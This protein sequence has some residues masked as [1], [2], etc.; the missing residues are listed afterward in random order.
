MTLGWEFAIIAWLYIFGAASTAAAYDDLS[1]GRLGMFDFFII[2][3]WP[4]L[5]PIYAVV[6]AIYEIFE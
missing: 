3:M 1:S 6:K 2:A 4:V 5:L